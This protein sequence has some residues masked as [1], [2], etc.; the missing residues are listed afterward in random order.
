MSKLW[1]YNYFAVAKIHKLN[2]EEVL[3]LSVYAVEDEP[4]ENFA[5]GCDNL[6]RAFY[7]GFG[8]VPDQ[9]PYH[10]TEVSK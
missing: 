3:S 2:F 4:M 8:I 5:D 6:A 9:A 10:E 1:I 7:Y